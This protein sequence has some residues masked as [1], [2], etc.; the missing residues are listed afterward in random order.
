MPFESSSPLFPLNLFRNRFRAVS[1][2]LGGLPDVVEL[3]GRIVS[4]LGS[5]F[6][7]ISVFSG[8]PVTSFSAS[9]DLVEGRGGS[10]LAR[11]GDAPLPASR[12]LPLFGR[13]REFS[14]HVVV[15]TRLKGL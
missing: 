9:P 14:D 4:L 5:L 1:S 3:V 7:P 2:A 8:L 6:R 15:L 13:S 11:P 12:S 10:V